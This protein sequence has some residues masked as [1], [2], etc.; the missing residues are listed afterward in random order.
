MKTISK[1]TLAATALTV[2]L[3]VPALASPGHDGFGH[4]DKMCDQGEMRHGER[5]EG[6]LSTLKSELKLTPAQEPAWAAFEQ[7]VR[8]QFADRAEAHKQM[9]KTAD[10]P[11]EA[12]I[13]H[14]E[15][16]L[17]GMKAV[18]KARKDLYEKLTAEQKAI[19]DQHFRH[20]PRGPHGA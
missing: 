16:R 7:A 6:R 17:A 3:A 9:Q 2:A 13:A 1:I 11:M 14:M 20:Q 10:D 18:A 4:G 8:K 19:A 15:Q 5:M 12:R